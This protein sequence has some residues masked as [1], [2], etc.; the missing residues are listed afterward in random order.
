L[1][2]K[3]PRVYKR[4]GLSQKKR[5]TLKMNVGRLAVISFKTYLKLLK[6]KSC[7]SIGIKI[8]K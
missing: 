6:S 8:S 7:S 2:P 5:T 1:V 3:S 4:P